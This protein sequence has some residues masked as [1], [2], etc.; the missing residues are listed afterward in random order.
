MA[1]LPS[2]EQAFEA[3]VRL[4]LVTITCRP[5]YPQ[6]RSMGFVHSTLSDERLVIVTARHVFVL[7]NDPMKYVFAFADGT[8]AEIE[9][10]ICSSSTA[11]DLIFL[12]AKQ[13]PGYRPIIFRR[14]KQER[15]FPRVL[16][17]CRN[18]TG[19]ALFPIRVAKQ[20]PVR[21]LPEYFFMSPES[22]A[23]REVVPGNNLRR[24]KTLLDAGWSR[25]NLAVLYSRPGF[26]GSPIFDD[27]WNLYGM[28]SQG[29]AGDPGESTGD[30]LAYYP[31]SYIDQALQRVT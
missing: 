9:R 18:V 19:E 5:T 4:P 20:T 30:K 6:G 3:V 25:L 26:S 11:D 7:G 12:I 23:L 28:G 8:E 2:V 16:Y 21:V 27:T 22:E 1:K 15:V 31:A 29:T 10:I 13:R 24:I 14:P 17:N